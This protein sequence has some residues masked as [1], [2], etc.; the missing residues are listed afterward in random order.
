MVIAIIGVLVAL[1]L[2]AVQAAREA[3]RRSQC[4]NNLRQVGL[5]LNG[6]HGVHQELP[7]GSTYPLDANGV[8][9]AIAVLPFMEQNALFESIDAARTS[10][11][12]IGGTSFWTSAAAQ[13]IATQPVYSLTCPSDSLVDSFVLAKRGSS[14]GAPA[15]VGG[16]WNPVNSAGLWYPA[17]IGPTNPDGCDYCPKDASGR[18]ALWCCQG[19]DW[20]SKDTSFYPDF[21]KDPDGKEGE[22]AGLF[23]RYPH[24]YAFRQCTDGVSNTVM[25]GETLP[26]HN[27]FNGLYGLNFPVA[28]HS[29]PINLMKSDEGAPARLDWSFVSGYKSLHPGGANFAMGDASVHFFNETIDFMA[30]AALGS[31]AGDETAEV[32]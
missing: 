31:R 22:S 27:V 4:T 11:A 26:A 19:C 3:A 20:G 17:S 32:P 18:P 16:N 28:S 1:L 6:Y 25:A 2:P 24:A 13:K 12:A 15:G 9:W 7:K 30:Y 29:I 5:A 21:C 23:V 14:T 10:Y 8:S